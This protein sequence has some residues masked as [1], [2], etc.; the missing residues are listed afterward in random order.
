M[1]CLVIGVVHRHLP[2]TGEI[3]FAHAVYATRAS[4]REHQRTAAVSLPWNKYILHC[5]TC[6]CHAEGVEASIGESSQ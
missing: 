5:R 2:L 3:W 1:V 6:R 4:D